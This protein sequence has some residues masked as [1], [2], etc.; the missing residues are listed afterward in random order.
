MDGVI[1][2]IEKLKKF[3]FNNVLS[4]ILWFGVEIE[5]FYLR[6]FNLEIVKKFGVFDNSLVFFYIGNVYVVNIYEVRSLYLVVVIL[7]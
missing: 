4:L 6:N 3:V 5:Y 1:V 7:N 2:I